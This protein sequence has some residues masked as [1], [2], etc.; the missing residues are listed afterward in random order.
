MNHYYYSRVSLVSSP[1]DCICKN[2]IEPKVILSF[3]LMNDV[4]ITKVLFPIVEDN[5]RT[6]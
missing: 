5:R 1:F 4:A 2:R 3:V 6:L